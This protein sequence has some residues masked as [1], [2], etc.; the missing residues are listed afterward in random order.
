MRIILRG[1]SCFIAVLVLTACD[2]YSFPESP[3]ATIKTLSVIQNNDEITLRADIIKLGDSPI[4]NHGFVWNDNP[5]LVSLLIGDQIQLGA[6]STTGVYE[7]KISGAG[8][9]KGKQYW[10]MALVDSEDY[11]VRGDIIPFIFN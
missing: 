9:I 5:A 4:L 7:A 10:V 11:E 2:D 3:Y 6:T 8:L 1:V